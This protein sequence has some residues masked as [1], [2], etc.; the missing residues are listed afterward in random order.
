M[1]ININ[2][3]ERSSVGGEDVALRN[4]LNDHT[5]ISANI[6]SFKNRKLRALLHFILSPEYFLRSCRQ[7]NTVQIIINPFPSISL[8]SIL[9]TSILGVRQRWYIHNFGLSCVSGTHYKDKRKC[10]DCS[11]ER[12]AH[13]VKCSGSIDRFILHNL[14]NRCFLNLFLSFT[15][16]KIYAVSEYQKNLAVQKGIPKSKIIIAGNKL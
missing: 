14:I 8:L 15:N 1:K 4:I 11:R 10:F 9:L 6:E 13:S 3:N 5:K 7:Q 16:N 2:H 12:N